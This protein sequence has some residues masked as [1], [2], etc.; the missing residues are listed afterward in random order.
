MSVKYMP[1]IEE[2][3]ELLKQMI[4]EQR[5]ELIRL[6]NIENNKSKENECLLK[7]GNSYKCPYC[8][9]NK[10]CKN[11]KRDKN[12]QQFKCRKCNKN[13]SIRINTIFYYTHESVQIWQKYIELFSQGLSLRKIAKQ[14]HINLITSFYWRHKILETLQC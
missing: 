11:G 12:S 10:I 3:R 2:T 7:L 14:L 13:Y 9:S 8:W 6:C 4:E 1:S 5:L